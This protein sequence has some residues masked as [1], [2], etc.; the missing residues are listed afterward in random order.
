MLAPMRPMTPRPLEWI[1]VAPVRASRNRR[2]GV[3]AATAWAAIADHEGWATWFPNISRVEPGTPAEGVGGSRVVH[4]GNAVKAREEFLAWDP[5]SRFS[6]TLVSASPGGL[7]SMNEDIRVTPDGP[8]ACTVTYTMGLDV[9]GARLLR[10]VL[11]RVLGKAISDGLAG[12]A[13]HVGG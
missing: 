12:M 5:G 7:R 11:C 10:P 3:P 9:R 8:D 6:F 1:D 13:A 2:M 4:I